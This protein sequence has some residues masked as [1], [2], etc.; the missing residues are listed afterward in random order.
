MLRM[1]LQEFAALCKAGVSSVGQWEQG[2][3]TGM[4]E[5]T[6]H[7]LAKA[8][9]ESPVICTFEWL[10]EGKGPAPTMRPYQM[11]PVPPPAP[12]DLVS[13]EG[14]V[15]EVSAFAHNSLEAVVLQVSDQAMAPFFKKGDYVGGYRCNA[16]DSKDFI[17]EVCIVQTLDGQVLLR[18]FEGQVED[19]NLYRLSAVQVDPT[20]KQPIQLD[21]AL[22]SVALVLRLWRSKD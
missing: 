18:R 22:V 15:A 17:G 11:T 19:S 16:K 2:R 13:S 4:V 9:Q 1:T 20:T 12:A 3:L 8:L 14:I 6:A 21:T 10:L 7:R 5:G